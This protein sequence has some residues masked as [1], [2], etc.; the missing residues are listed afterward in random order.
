MVVRMVWASPVQVSRTIRSGTLIKQLVS[1][2]V[3]ASGSGVGWGGTDG[4]SGA[5]EPWLRLQFSPR[6]RGV[7][8]GCVGRSCDLKGSLVQGLEAF[9]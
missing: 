3:E 4:S 5:A 7:V 2:R 9:C 6:M 1:G 8:L